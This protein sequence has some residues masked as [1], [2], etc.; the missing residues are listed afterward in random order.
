L[1]KIYLTFHI[2]VIVAEA[3]AAN[4]VLKC[5]VMVVHSFVATIS[6]V[7]GVDDKNSTIAGQ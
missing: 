2:A 7:A 5:H 6:F 1:F 3:P 4:G